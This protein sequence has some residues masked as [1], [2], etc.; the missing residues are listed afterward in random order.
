MESKACYQIDPLDDPRW[1]ELVAKHAKSSVFHTVPW[2]RAL[3]ST[4]GYKPIGFTA[5]RPDED[6]TNGMVFCR[7]DSMLTGRRLVSLPFSDHCEPLFDWSFDLEAVL[8]GVQAEYRQQKLNYV[9]VRSTGQTWLETFEKFGC[10]PA[11]RYFLHRVNLRPSLNDVFQ[12][13]DKDSVQRR[14][15]RA[16]RAGLSERYGTSTDLLND[17]YRLFVAMRRSR[18]L[19]PSP[20]VW[21]KNLIETHGSALAIRIAYTNLVPVAAIVTIEFGRTLYYKYGCSDPR[22]NKF[23]GMPWLFWKAICAAKEKGISE[24]DLGRT[25]SDH[26]GLLTF[27]NHWAAAPSQLFYLRYPKAAAQLQEGWKSRVAETVFS[28]MPLKLLE[29]VGRKLY[30]HYG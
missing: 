22:F 18:A 20:Y 25:R 15:Q 10:A 23:A 26:S 9:E 29:L 19:P 6:L 14:I 28:A 7:I 17:F 8:Q 1:A 4:Y 30:R 24:F 11:E 13:F 5:C 3:R 21:F 2:L 27:K 12:S 16:E